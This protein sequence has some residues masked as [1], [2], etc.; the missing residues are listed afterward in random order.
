MWKI[1]L[2]K[3]IN[4]TTH[5]PAED[6]LE[7]ELEDN[8]AD[9]I[10]SFSTYINKLFTKWARENKINITA[11]VTA[12]KLAVLTGDIVIGKQDYTVS[13]RITG[14]VKAT[15]VNI[16]TH[17]KEAIYP[18]CSKLGYQ[19]NTKS[20]TNLIL[21]YISYVSKIETKKKRKGWAV[22]FFYSKTN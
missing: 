19:I 14:A 13:S 6:N 11:L 7:I 21:A 9:S 8:N 20:I 16:G 18:I 5:Y 12:F 22:L 2:G 3:N 4:R 1:G 17:L 10:T 15:E